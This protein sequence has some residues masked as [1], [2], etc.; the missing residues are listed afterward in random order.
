LQP[1]RPFRWDEM[2]LPNHLLDLLDRPQ[3]LVIFVGPVGSRKTAALNAM[4]D[5]VNRKHPPKHV[6]TVEDPPEFTHT[7][8]NGY[9]HQREIGHTTPS[10]RTAIEGALR[11]RPDFLIVGEARDGDTIDAALLAS[12]LGRLCMTSMHVETT[13][14]AIMRISQSFSGSKRDEVMATF[15][16]S[17]LA[18][19]ALRPVPTVNGDIVLAYEILR[20]TKATR[21]N[22]SDPLKLRGMLLEGDNMI[23]MES[24]LERLYRDG[25]ITRETA[26][27]FAPDPDALADI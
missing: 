12:K 21:P 25:K 5:H 9:F 2:G 14:E 10:Y 27:A 4:L 20:N 13:T 17:M 19:V 15:E 7:P 6:V 8:I 1:P 24:C 3:G 11:M 26:I 22:L 18:I 16:S 23:R